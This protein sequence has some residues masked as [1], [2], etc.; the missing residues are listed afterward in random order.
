MPPLFAPFDVR[1]DPWEVDYGSETPLEPAGSEDTP[2]VEPGVEVRP[3]D[4]APVRPGAAGRVERLYF[5]DGVRRLETRLQVRREDQR[6]HGA[7]GSFAVGCVRVEAGAAAYGD[8]EAERQVVLG[9]DQK[10][11]HDVP[12]RDRVVYRAEAAAGDE[13]DVPLRHIQ[14]QMRRAEGQLARRL[15]D[16]AETLVVADGPLTFEDSGR[17]LAVGLVKRVTHLY[18]PPPLVQV[19]AVLPA[20]T[21]T[22]L[23]ALHS[24]QHGFPRLS[25]FLRLADPQPGESELHGVVRLEVREAVGPAVARLLADLT[26]V[27]LPRFA[28][29]RSRDPRSPQNLLPIGALEDRLRR[30]LGDPRLLR[31]WIEALVTK[32][33]ARAR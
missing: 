32:E 25:W 26:A 16:A 24:R 4:W 9:S 31:R 13:P 33:V 12:V 1:V 18:L 23:F 19:V 7:F 14:T 20:G 6:L 17:G 10:L 22:P 15:A 11:P 3:E 30:D 29:P 5:V 21:R 8:R 28:P 27:R 2:D